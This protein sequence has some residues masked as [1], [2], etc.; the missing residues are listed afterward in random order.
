MV[1]YNIHRKFVL[2]CGRRAAFLVVVDMFLV[3]LSSFPAVLEFGGRVGRC[4]R[5]PR[6]L[7]KKI[8][9]FDFSCQKSVILVDRDLRASFN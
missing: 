3:P 8:K 1:L 5:C 2:E 9:I 7:K 4:P 6:A